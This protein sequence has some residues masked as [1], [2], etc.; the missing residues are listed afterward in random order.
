MS[1]T[2]G[3]SYSVHASSNYCSNICQSVRVSTRTQTGLNNKQKRLWL[4][5][6]FYQISVKAGREIGQINTKT[7]TLSTSSILGWEQK[8]KT[9]LWSV[10]CVC[11]I[12]FFSSSLFTQFFGDFLFSCPN[13]IHIRTL[14]I[15]LHLNLAQSNR[16][17][18]TSRILFF[19]FPPRKNLHDAE[20]FPERV[21]ELSK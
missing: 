15:H 11:L 8:Q 6:Q 2:N 21:N 18:I 17:R 12:C 10:H 7:K 9:L 19:F 5:G 4:Q 3:C 1:P 13:K 16:W 14:L 20:C